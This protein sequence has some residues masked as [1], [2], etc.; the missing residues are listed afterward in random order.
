MN[1]EGVGV[2]ISNDQYCEIWKLPMLKVETVEKLKLF[3]VLLYEII[4][5]FSIIWK[6]KLYFF[7][8]VN[9][10]IFYNF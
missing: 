2:E 4:F 3:Y 7:S 9:A 6:L 10:P 5:S 8:N 1:T